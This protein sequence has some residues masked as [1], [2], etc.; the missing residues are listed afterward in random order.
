MATCSS[1]HDVNQL[2]KAFR[3]GCSPRFSDHSDPDPRAHK[4]SPTST[5][6]LK[7]PQAGPKLRRP[8]YQQLQ[9]L[10]IRFTFQRLAGVLKQAAP[11]RSS[12]AISNQGEVSAAPKA[13]NSSWSR[14]CTTN[15]L[16]HARK[17]VPKA[18]CSK[19]FPQR[20][21]LCLH[22]RIYP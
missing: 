11:C 21:F 3:P 4:I 17:W 2:Q 6:S 9:G 8:T 12:A 18:S 7:S 13:A 22:M 19:G 15:R 14:P 5:S 1:R 10:S 20:L 16:K